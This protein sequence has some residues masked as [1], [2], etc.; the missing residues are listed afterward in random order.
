MNI[1]LIWGIVQV[2]GGVLMLIQAYLVAIDK[3]KLSKSSIV[4]YCIII[5]I[6]FL[7]G[8]LKYF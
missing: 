3:I 6:S 8:S 2:V 4:F 5:G 1:G 7:S